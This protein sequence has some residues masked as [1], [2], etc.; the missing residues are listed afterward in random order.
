[1]L[2]CASARSLDGVIFFRVRDLLSS[3]SRSHSRGGGPPGKDGA[4]RLEDGLEDGARR[5]LSR[6]RR[7]RSRAARKKN[8]VGTHHI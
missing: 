6:L 8:V 3:H 2:R 5:R 7:Q 1:M 4:R